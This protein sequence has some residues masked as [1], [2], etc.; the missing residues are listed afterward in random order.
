MIL[1]AVSGVAGTIATLG[2]LLGHL[3]GGSAARVA[4]ALAILAGLAGPVGY[5]I[6]TAATAHTGAIITA[7]PSSGQG[8]GP[9]GGGGVAGGRGGPG[10]QT[11]SRQGA[12]GNGQGGTAQGGTQGGGMAQ[13]GMTPKAPAQQGGGTQ[14]GQQAGT[15]QGGASS[16]SQ[17]GP[18]FQGGSRNGG[19]GGGGGMGGLN[20]GTEVS[21]A[22]KTLL[23]ADAGSYTWVAAA[24]GSNTAASYQLAT[25]YPVMAVGGYNG[26]DPAPTLAQFKQ[27]VAQGKI[28]YFISSGTGGS[29]SSSG[30]N[31]SS[32]IASW[33]AK[34]FTPKTVGD[35][36]VYDLS[37]ASS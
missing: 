36:T 35:S 14:G 19:P 21:S 32:Q 4:L 34:N 37:Q 20:G 13:G 15:G 5:S 30:S 2:L 7:G 11:G 3:L 25:G 33:V 17:A 22:A 1:A 24:I 8:G 28:H 12:P 9:G 23:S 29:T 31:A 27:M 10:G 18:A 6:D 26:T 16:R